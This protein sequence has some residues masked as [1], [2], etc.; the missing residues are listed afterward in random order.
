MSRNR[1]S[2]N[3]GEMIKQVLFREIDNVKVINYISYE[4]YLSNYS[5]VIHH[6]GELELFMNVLKEL[7]QL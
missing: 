4:K 5:Y 3:Y 7:Y 2:Y 6:G 1:V